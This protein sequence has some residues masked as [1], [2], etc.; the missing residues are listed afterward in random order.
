MR[1]LFIFLLMTLS[2]WGDGP[3]AFEEQRYV[4]SLDRIFE[5]SGTIRFDAEGMEVVYTA[6]EARRIVYG[7]DRLRTY[8][9]DGALLQEIDLAE[10]PSM[11]LYMQF[12]L[13]LYRDD[14]EALRHY[15]T[16]E[17][18]EE[19]MHLAPIPPTDKAVTSVEVVKAADAV[20]KI[21]TQMSNG[22][23]ITIDITR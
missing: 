19:G 18:T 13:W 23:A 4:Y 7:E 1:A 21:Q 9:G 6:P 20:R 3:F 15:F 14:T 17:P 12:M 22:D 8:D 10:A 5:L 2:L 11:R 16:I